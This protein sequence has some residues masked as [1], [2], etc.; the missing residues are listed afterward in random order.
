MF[1]KNARRYIEKR[2]TYFT[3]KGHR[4][5]IEKDIDLSPIV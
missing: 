1:H 2:R 3:E 5:C 4:C